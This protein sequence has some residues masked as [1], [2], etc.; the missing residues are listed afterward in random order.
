MRT[1]CP[2]GPNL[3]LGSGHEAGKESELRGE[4][5]SGSVPVHFAVLLSCCTAYARDMV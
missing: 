4:P 1:G 5:E 2:S 3:I